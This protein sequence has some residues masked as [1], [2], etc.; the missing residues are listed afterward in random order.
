L[1]EDRLK[2]IH[3]FLEAFATPNGGELETGEGATI[4]TQIPSG[5]QVACWGLVI[6][7]GG[8]GKWDVKLRGEVEM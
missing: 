6:D 7:L 5:D 2:R 4:G 3:I 8:C 1:C